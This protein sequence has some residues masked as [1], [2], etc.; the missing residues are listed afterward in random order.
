[1]VV[2]LAVAPGDEV[3]AGDRLAVV[4]AMKMETAI[5]APFAGRVTRLLVTANTQVDAGAP[6]SS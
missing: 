4:E 6:C 1:M 2:S 3:Q 5:S